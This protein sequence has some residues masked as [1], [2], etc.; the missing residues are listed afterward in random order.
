MIR[1]LDR[2]T[3]NQIAAG[4]VVER[5]ASVV[6][7]LVENSLDAG[8]R[9]IEVRIRGGGIDLIE[10]ADDGTG[11]PAEQVALALE[12]H[13]TSKIKAIEDLQSVTTLGFRGEAL[14]SIASVSRLEMIT[15]TGEGAGVRVEVHGSRLVSENHVAARRGT[16]VRVR[17]LFYNTPARKKHLASRSTEVARITETVYTAAV[18]H[19]EVSFRLYSDNRELLFTPGRGDLMEALAAVMGPDITAC[20]LPL[21]HHD[22]DVKLTGYVGG[23]SAARSSRDRQLFFVNR[24]PVRDSVLREAVEDAFR[25]YLTV[26]RYP[27]AVLLLEI[28]PS[29]VDVNVHPTKTQVRFV[30]PRRVY[31]ATHRA[32]RETL[33]GQTSFPQ[34][35]LRPLPRSPGVREQPASIVKEGTAKGG[36]YERADDLFTV[37]DGGP[38][39]GFPQ[40]EPL[41]QIHSTY[42]VARDTLSGDL[43][44]VDQH[45]AHERIYYDALCRGDQHVAAQDLL[46]P[47][48]LDLT[49]AEMAAWEGA[50]ELLE[51]LGF[52]SEPFGLNS[53]IVR[54]AP[55]LFAE[56]PGDKLL[57]VLSHLRKMLSTVDSTPDSERARRI[58][59]SCKAAIKARQRLDRAAM[60]ELLSQLARTQD[61][62][63]CP[64]GRPTAVR[65]PRRE[66][67]RLF[68]RT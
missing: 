12:R 5:P 26:G 10:V 14:P 25:G 30:D 6:K 43:F 20:L 66:L 32:V 60:E 45:A 58:M 16:V 15:S 23:P 33:A 44:I 62:L 4:E 17:D 50:A 55:A 49:P 36:Q 65:V 48:T 37:T 29:K 53:V 67:E 24:R 56:E 54:T 27:L 63:T 51:R 38:S 35:I 40:L 8:A 19:P 7:E 64:H 57:E 11:I 34:A 22:G 21:E 46:F 39:Q 68:K 41:G 31:S 47:L 61:P 42:I 52:S 3:A 18:A 1:V 28:H 13:A 59:A 9:C 2:Q